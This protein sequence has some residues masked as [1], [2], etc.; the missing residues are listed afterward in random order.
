MVDQLTFPALKWA[1]SKNM[2]WITIDIVDVDKTDINLSD[3]GKLTVR[4]ES[5]G[6]K[7]GFDMELFNGVDKENSGWNVK[8]RNVAFRLTKKEDDN[9]EYWPRL[10]KEKVKN[11]RITIDWSKWVD[12]DEAD[13]APAENEGMDG[14][15]GFGGQ[16]GM[17]GMGGPGG[18]GGPGGMGGM[19]GM[20]GM[21]G[22][23]G[24]GGPGGP[25]GP[26][27]MGGMDMAQM[28][29][30]MGGGAGGGAPPG[31]AAPG[32]GGGMGGMGGMQMPQ[33][34]QAQQ[35][36]PHVMT[37]ANEMVGTIIGKGGSSIREIRAMSGAK[38]QVSQSQADAPVAER[39]ITISGAPESINVAIYL[40]N[41]VISQARPQ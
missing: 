9:E 6:Q 36:A 18:P 24:M 27:G 29:Q 11:S 41:Q 16:G 8:G 2:I 19:P 17:P 26:G 21:G 15:Q 30:G 10:Q 32:G 38:V 13:A 4:A 1:Q 12:E 23:P 28:M 39:T 3:D 14:M 34:G 40:V 31:V 5:H 33:Y 22:M 25:G 35:A 20:G 7:I 37:V